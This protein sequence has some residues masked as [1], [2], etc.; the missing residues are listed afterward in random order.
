MPE[1]NR[2]PAERR[3]L[4]VAEFMAEVER[5]IGHTPASERDH[6]RVTFVCPMCACAQDGAD[7][8][9][10]G[11]GRDWAEVETHVGFTCIGRWKKAKSPRARPDGKPC[12][13]TVGGLFKVHTI[14]VVD[15]EG[16]AH[17]MFE[18]APAPR[19]AADPDEAAA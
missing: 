13:W 11:A 5:Q 19:S 2:K 1:T 8:V 16:T 18:L 3:R 14:E 9:Q 7:F 6:L 12:D 15:E 4:T 17:P 10:A